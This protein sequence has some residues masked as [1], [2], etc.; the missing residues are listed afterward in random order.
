MSIFDRNIDNLLGGV[1]SIAEVNRPQNKLENSI[2][3]YNSLSK[4]LIRRPPAELI[5][6]YET[7]SGSLDPRDKVQL[8]E[9]TQGNKYLF[10]IKK[11]TGKL[12]VTNWE[13][14]EVLFNGI[15]GYLLCANPKKDIK[16]IRLSDTV[17]ILN[18]EREV[19]AAETPNTDFIGFNNFQK[20]IYVKNGEYNR[21]Y[22]IKLEYNGLEYTLA[23]YDTPDESDV[24]AVDLTHNETIANQLLQQLQAFDYVGNSIPIDPNFFFRKRNVISY[25]SFS[26]VGL[27]N[28]DFTLTGTDGQDNNNMV[29]INE[30]V[31]SV[32]DLPP[33]AGR[34]VIVRVENLQSTDTD[35]YYLKFLNDT[36][37]DFIPL[38]GIWTETGDPSKDVGFNLDTMPIKVELN[39][40]AVTPANIDWDDRLIGDDNTNKLPEFVGKRVNDIGFYRNRLF[41]V[42]DEFISFSESDS[43][44]NFFKTSVVTELATAPVELQ[45]TDNDYNPI[46]IATVHQD[47]LFLFSK[48][49]QFVIS[50]DGNVLKNGTAYIRKVSSFKMD[51]EV[52]P[53][54]NNDRLFFADNTER[55]KPVIYEYF[56]NKEGTARIFPI[57][58]EMR[59][60]QD[61][62]VEK[63]YAFK[64]NIFFKFAPFRIKSPI[65]SYG[66]SVVDLWSYQYETNNESEKVVD[67][68]QKWEFKEGIPYAEVI[69]EDEIVFIYKDGDRLKIELNDDINREY[70]KSLG[71]VNQDNLREKIHLDSFLFIDS[72]ESSGG[73]P[74]ITYDSFLNRTS[75]NL[76]TLQANRGYLNSFN[77]FDL[78]LDTTVCM[79]V[80]ENDFPKNQLINII[81]I[82]D[83][84]IV[85]D[86]DFT[87]EDI[88]IGNVYNTEIELSKFFIRD[89]N[90][91]PILDGRT[92]LLKL[93]INHFETIAYE[94]DIIR[95]NRDA[96]TK[97]FDNIQANAN[98]QKE[99]DTGVFN[100]KINSRNDKTKLKIKS[101]DWSP[102]AVQGITYRVD[103]TK[104][105]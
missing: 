45:Y 35:D 103:Y 68:F 14:M 55:N 78:S 58:D 80:K 82:Q 86:G 2:N 69:D 37:S 10:E 71:L 65:D 54:S 27:N 84:L 62:I 13:T 79:V 50:T 26:Q 22:E 51:T 101:K 11:L 34:N 17:V 77:T 53:L 92:Q 89:R 48:E 24:N 5:E 81:D 39:T 41:F 46:D 83:Q 105:R 74:A 85:L 8:V 40:V 49:R 66:E 52:R 99:L 63:I 75:I 33:F 59:N 12:K 23:T 43:L 1:S 30:S 15:D 38:E 4:G 32:D 96:K 98:V 29:V 94:V 76:I 91:S 104:T 9:D 42:Y 64:N 28:V 88:I 21:R 73:T 57:N 3:T 7:I 47:N 25:G 93:S 44:F 95:N 100:V 18:S 90:N 16:I 36:S 6:R 87:F 102:L 67:A 31:R 61:G 56:I 72:T 60:K 20:T 70:P 19:A 97:R